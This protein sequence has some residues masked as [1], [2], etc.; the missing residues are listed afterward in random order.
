[1]EN[2]K[3]LTTPNSRDLVPEN[4]ILSIEPN[5]ICT[6][7]SSTFAI[8]RSKTWPG[9]FDCTIEF[10][11]DPASN[12]SCV[13]R[14]LA[15]SGLNNETTL[16][17]SLI[18]NK[19]ASYFNRLNKIT[20]SDDTGIWFKTYSLLNEN[21]IQTG[22][23]TFRPLN[24][25]YFSLCQLNELDQIIVEF[26][27]D[28][29]GEGSVIYFPSEA[30]N[31]TVEPE[32]LQRLW[33]FLPPQ[34]QAAFES[35]NNTPIT[36]EVLNG[37]SEAAYLIRVAISESNLNMQQQNIY[38]YKGLYQ[39]NFST[40][41]DIGVIH[42][43]NWSDVTWIS[44]PN[45]PK[46]LN[47]F[48]KDPLFQIS[49]I[50]KYWNHQFNHYLK[51]ELENNNIAI[52]DVLKKG[53][54]TFNLKKPKAVSKLRETYRVHAG[55]YTIPVTT[56]VLIAFIHLAGAKG[57][58]DF[59]NGKWNDAFIDQHG[60]LAWRYA[61]KLGLAPDGKPYDVSKI[62]APGSAGPIPSLKTMNFTRYSEGPDAIQPERFQTSS[63]LPLQIS[64]GNHTNPDRITMGPKQG[65]S[66]ITFLQSNANLKKIIEAWMKTLIPTLSER[67]I[68]HLE[69]NDFLLLIE[70][71]FTENSIKKI[72]NEFRKLF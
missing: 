36:A 49:C 20:D 1:M 11:P 25:N 53:E 27:R 31:K 55:T 15:G 64:W 22:Q 16:P 67:K 71:A 56:S 38:G 28:F 62:I 50:K 52:N 21:G 51:H 48:L 59:I 65:F 8:C 13:A 30:C 2:I 39:T 26:Q 33:R 60:T 44:N 17:H 19:I 57:L 63:Y 5:N 23:I 70:G 12:H 29:A 9:K 61:K 40:L 69:N 68:Y 14:S 6:D 10:N 41:K 3:F 66:Y 45:Q 54:I 32:K 7:N 24:G 4:V 72:R 43:N 47:T 18:N 34:V 42:G 37:H 46:C 58:A 35:E